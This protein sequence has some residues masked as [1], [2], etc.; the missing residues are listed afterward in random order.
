MSGKSIQQVLSE[1]RDEWMALPGVV[2]AGIGAEAGHPCIRIF[3][4]EEA[5]T[6]RS[7]LP[8][9]LHGYRIIVECSGPLRA[10]PGE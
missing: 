6:V 3:V 4:S 7:R 9:E 10:L 8:R 1:H 5:D 2:A